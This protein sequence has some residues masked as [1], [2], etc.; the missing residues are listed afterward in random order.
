MMPDVYCTHYAV[1]CAYNNDQ[2]YGVYYYTVWLLDTTQR[3]LGT[4]SLSLSGNNFG[5][6]QVLATVTV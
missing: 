5:L 6:K 1:E 4:Q 3:K 2:E